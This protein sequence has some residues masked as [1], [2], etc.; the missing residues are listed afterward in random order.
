VDFW[1]LIHDLPHGFISEVVARQLGSFIGI[2]LE[3]YAS[4]I[5]LAYKGIMRLRVR[6]DSRK[7]GAWRSRW[8]VE[9]GSGGGKSSNYGNST[10]KPIKV[11]DLGHN[12]NEYSNKFD[13]DMVVLEEENNPIRQNDGLKGARFQSNASEVSSNVDLNEASSN[14]L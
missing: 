5:Q 11:G 7:T 2:F 3:Y 1:I 12:N 8:L 6:V 13:E 14:L 4:T 9:D 10:N